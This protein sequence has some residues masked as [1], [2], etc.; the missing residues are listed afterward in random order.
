MREPEV[1]SADVAVAERGAAAGGTTFIADGARLHIPASVVDIESFRR[2]ADTEEFPERG[3]I[4]WLCGEVWADMSK[5]QIFTHV[6]LKGEF[7]RAL[8]NLVKEG[9]LG[10]T[11]PDGA[12][13]TNLPADIAGKPDA[14]FLAAE[15]ID[16]GRVRFVEGAERGYVEVEGSPDMVLEV[17]SDSSVDKDTGVL[18]DAYWQAGI[19][20]YWLVDARGD[21]LRFDVFRRGPKGYKRSPKKHGWVASPI[22]GK[23]FRL[24]VKTDKAGRP[25]YTLDVR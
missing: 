5:E 18:L 9:R 21:D 20:E 23:S 15:T 10:V 2:W 19:P 25:D 17:V 14:M 8:A 16:S 22:F 6:V 1:L 4:W 3:N 13:L 11:L 12:F 7:F 24:S